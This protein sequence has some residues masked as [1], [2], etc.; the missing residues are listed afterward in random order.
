V[1]D[2]S[3]AGL[4]G[5]RSVHEQEGEMFREARSYVRRHHVGML[6]LFVALW[7]VQR[8]RQQQRRHRPSRGMGHPLHDLHRIADAPGGLP[9]QRVGDGDH[10]RLNRAGGQPASASLLATAAND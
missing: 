9:G 6:A 2:A 1:A 3:C 10:Q 5:A 7:H 4:L 8:Q